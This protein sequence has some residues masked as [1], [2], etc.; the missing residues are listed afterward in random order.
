VATSE[1]I[2]AQKTSTTTS[3]RS[4]ELS[5]TL[6]LCPSDGGIEDVTSATRRL[7]FSGNSSAKI[8]D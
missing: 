1:L 8:R 7:R 5:V 3:L 6:L 2:P 4:N